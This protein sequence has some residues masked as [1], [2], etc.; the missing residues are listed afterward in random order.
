MHE[1]LP[2]EGRDRIALTL[3]CEYEEGVA[4]GGRIVVF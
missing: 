4:L 1:V 2:C 3:W